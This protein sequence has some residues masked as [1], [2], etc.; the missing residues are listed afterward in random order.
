MPFTYC[1]LIISG[2]VKIL[3]PKEDADFIIYKYLPRLGLSIRGITLTAEE[4]SD[5]I[6]KFGGM[7]IKI[8]YAFV[9]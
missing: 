1:S 3:I 7:L 8:L 9:W 5:L 6:H 2:L 4:K